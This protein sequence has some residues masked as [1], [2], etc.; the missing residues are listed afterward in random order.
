MNLIPLIG[1][2]PIFFSFFGEKS[3]SVSCYHR[4]DVVVFPFLCPNLTFYHFSSMFRLEQNGNFIV[5]LQIRKA[6]FG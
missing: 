1:R 4:E 3:L 5:S 2:L 6:F